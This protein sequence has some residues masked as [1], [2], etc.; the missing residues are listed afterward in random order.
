[1]NEGGKE[2]EEFRFGSRDEAE[3]STKEYLKGVEE[4][5]A[6]VE[7]AGNGE[8][9]KEAKKDETKTEKQPAVNNLQGLIRKKPRTT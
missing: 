6:V 3:R 9:E 7:V 2:V 4:G 8:K 1:M 5:K